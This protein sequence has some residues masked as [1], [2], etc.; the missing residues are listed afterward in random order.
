MKVQ[1]IQQKMA[2]TV[3]ILP[4]TNHWHQMQ[5]KS[6]MFSYISLGLLEGILNVYETGIAFLLDQEASQQ[7]APAPAQEEDIL[8]LLTKLEKKTVETPLQKKKHSN[9]DAQN[10]TALKRTAKKMKENRTVGTIARSP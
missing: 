7:L 9:L 6:R 8:V 3:P 2:L 4:A 10:I 5:G 1:E